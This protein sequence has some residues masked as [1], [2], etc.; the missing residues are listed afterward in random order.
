MADTAEI[1]DARSGR[2]RMIPIE[3]PPGLLLLTIPHVMYVT[4]YSERRVRALLAEGRLKDSSVDRVV[5]V[6]R[7]DVLRLIDNKPPR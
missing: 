1:E 3:P 7:M 6:R 5:R 2:Q 4:G